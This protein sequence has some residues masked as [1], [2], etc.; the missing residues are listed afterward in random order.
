MGQRRCQGACAV[1]RRIG[2]AGTSSL[3][4]SVLLTFPSSFNVVKLCI[5]RL[6]CV[7]TEREWA[8]ILGR[9]SRAWEIGWK[10]KQDIEKRR[11][12][13]T[14]K[15][16]RNDERDRQIETHGYDQRVIHGE[17]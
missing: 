1:G 6:H 10:R 7:V 17:K 12:K 15:K 8:Q 16:E 11:E 13:R 9:A 14:E 3:P 2:E 5:P 4:L